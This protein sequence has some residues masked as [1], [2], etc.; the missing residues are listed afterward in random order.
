M[1]FKNC[2]ELSPEIINY[3]GDD[4]NITKTIIVQPIVEPPYLRRLELIPPLL[5]QICGPVA[6]LVKE[7]VKREKSL[8][9]QID[10]V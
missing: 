8:S 3:N 5:D 1:E 6:L 2:I 9:A 10:F 7:F 4:E